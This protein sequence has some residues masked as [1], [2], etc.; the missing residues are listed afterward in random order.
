M[1]FSK[2][3]SNSIAIGTLCFAGASSAVPISGQIEFTGYSVVTGTS[4]NFNVDFED[5]DALDGLIALGGGTPSVGLP[6]DQAWAQNGTG[7]LLPIQNSF[8]TMFD[9]NSTGL[10]ISPLWTS[11]GFSFNLTSLNVDLFTIAG[12]VVDNVTLSG[13]GMLSSSTAGLDDT[14]YNW[15]YSSQGGLTFSASSDSSPVSEPSIIALMGFG[16]LGMVA[17]RRTKQKSA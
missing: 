5:Y 14:A 11:G 2:I 6:G 3:I 4:A 17:F 16:L 9:F 7:D 8:A 12:G 15:D 10:P 13:Q 1:K